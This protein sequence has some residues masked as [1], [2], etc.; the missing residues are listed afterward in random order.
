MTAIAPLPFKPPRLIELSESLLADHYQNEYGQCVQQL[1]QLEDQIAQIDVADI[2]ADKLLSLHQHRDALTSTATLHEI[3]F[4][5]LGGEDGL[6][7]PSIAPTGALADAMQAAFG[8][9]SQWQYQF[10]TLANAIA[11]PGWVVMSWSE[12]QHKL[13]LQPIMGNERL[14]AGT[15]PV[16]AIDLYAHAYEADH[17]SNLATYIDAFMKNLHWDRPLKRFERAVQSTNAPAGVSEL[18][19]LPPEALSQMIERGEAPQ[20]IDVCLADD[21]PKRYDTLPNARYLQAEKIDEWIDD[22]PKDQPIIAY[23]MY[24]FQVS[25]N[26]VAKLRSKGYNARMLAGGIATWRALGQPTEPLAQ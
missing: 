3:Y 14:P 6:G 17:G 2:D 5:C 22:L 12:G 18:D 11:A 19:P 13:V 16:M 7:S 8:G 24:G 1:N 4:D 9:Y 26:A 10:L 21:M 25:G 15:T 23:C 20:I